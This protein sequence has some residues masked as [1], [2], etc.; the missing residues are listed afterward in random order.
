M[1][2]EGLNSYVGTAA[3]ASGLN[4][5]Y[6]TRIGLDSPLD[7]FV[8]AIASQDEI[9]VIANVTSGN[10]AVEGNYKIRFAL[11]SDYWNQWTGSNGQ[12]VYWHDLIDMAPDQNGLPF[13]IDAN[14]TD[15]YQTAFNWPIRLNNIAVQD[16]NVSVVVFVQ[17]E[18]TK[19]IVQSAMVDLASDY[20]FTATSPV[21]NHLT[22]PNSTCTYDLTIS[23]VG[24]QPDTYDI[25]IDTEGLPAGWSFSYTTPDGDQ[26]GNYALSLENGEEYTS[27]ITFNTSANPGENGEILMTLT[28]QGAEAINYTYSF[29]AQNAGDILVVNGDPNGNYAD[30]YT[31]ALDAVFEVNDGNYS[32]WPYALRPLDFVEVFD[33]NVELVIWYLGNGGELDATAQTNLM[34]YLSGGGNLF[35]TGSAA[36]EQLNNTQLLLMMGADY[37]SRS[38]QT[39]VYGIEDDPVGNGFDASIVGGDGADIPLA[40]STLTTA[41]AGVAC[42]MYSAI[43]RAGIRNDGL[44]WKTL[45]LGFPFENIAG[46]D[47]RNSLM[48]NVL[49]YLYELDVDDPAGLAAA[50][51]VTF[52]L[53]QNYPNPFNPATDI[54]FSLP[55][56]ADISVNVF[57]LT[58]RH[59]TSLA[60][61]EWQPGYHSLTWNAENFASGIYLCRFHAEGGTQSYTA[62]RKMILLK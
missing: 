29:F 12:A 21:T 46:A 18:N 31:S 60:T 45:L 30:Y 41:D 56:L 47:S 32:I 59:V 15:Q 55:E 11:V 50:Q 37:H 19:E 24:L 2:G 14:Q 28:S 16:D 10:T 58:G 39:S 54:R 57:D 34:L 36:A 26:M 7:L 35:L 3:I 38:T 4:S 27:T 52:N 53:D 23:N 20:V 5:T 62:A 49:G 17:N 33:A 6:N 43:R 22:V 1:V 8:L 48:L 13:S 51:P 42:L 61:G 25:T 44:T 40:P 9:S